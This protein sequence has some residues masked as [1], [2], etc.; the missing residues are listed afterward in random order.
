[1]PKH[2]E[3]TRLRERRLENVGPG[4]DVGEASNVGELIKEVVWKMAKRNP[5]PGQP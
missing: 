5:V 4:V 3:S 2:Y 1:V